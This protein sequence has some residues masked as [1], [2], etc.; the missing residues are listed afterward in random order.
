M[1]R[2]RLYVPS[3]SGFVS[4]KKYLIM[5]LILFFIPAIF[6]LA[7]A[8]QYY[9]IE[10]SKAF[11]MSVANENIVVNAG[12]ITIERI[13]ETLQQDIVY[14]SEYHEFKKFVNS[15]QTKPYSD[16]INDYKLLMQS[17]PG[18]DQIRWID[19]DGWE[20]I[21]LDFKSGTPDAVEPESFQYKGD[22]YYFKNIVNLPEGTIYIS[23]F[24][25]NFDK[26][27]IEKPYKP[28]IRLGVPVVDEHGDRRGAFIINYL[29]K[30]LIKIMM[31]NTA[32]TNGR[33]MLLNSNGYW[34]KGRNANEEFGF[35]LGRKD[36]SLAHQ[37]P[38]IWNRISSM[39]SGSF[40]DEK[41]LWT[42]ETVYPLKSVKKNKVENDK[43]RWKIVSFV[44]L[45]KVYEASDERLKMITLSTL[46]I[47]SI[48]LIGS[49]ILT[50]LYRRQLFQSH[51]I[52]AVQDSIM[53]HD[54][55][56]K[57]VY[58]NE[59]AWKSRGYSHDEL[60]NMTVA[61]LDAPE[62]SSG[63]AEELKK[64]LEI[65]R[66]EGSMTIESEHICK[67][68]KHMP[69]EVNAKLLELDDEL[70]ILSSVRDITE[71]KKAR[72]EIE[73]LSKAIEQVDDVVYIT[74]RN[75]N[76]TY[77]NRA[78][79]RHTGYSKEE[80]IGQPSKIFK[81]GMHDLSFYKNLWYTILSGEVFRDTLINRKKN[82]DLYYEKK[83]ISPLKDDQYKVIGFVSTGKDVTEEVMI[84]QEISKM[85]T[86]DALT[87]VYNRRKL[88]EL[89]AL[90]QERTKRFGNP[91]SLLLLDID[92]FK[93]VNDKYGHNVGD[94]VLKHFASVVKENIRQID[95]LARWGGEEF[96]IVCPGTV[97]N[98]GMTLANKI[99]AAVEQSSFP[100][101]ERV[102]V[103]IGV[104]E[105][106]AKDSFASMIKR[107]DEGLYEAKAAGRN[108]AIYREE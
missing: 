106:L 45:S 90:E 44:P 17:K 8:Y 53:V 32:G 57:F 19:E 101:V 67:N 73:K 103:S 89:F 27:I 21:R 30:D 104:S 81:S 99:R 10:K 93:S 5:W 50:V 22:R 9:Q 78:F 71:H 91:L 34:L 4:V 49:I 96:I 40:K 2:D 83:T 35:M 39:E 6:I 18:Y 38:E 88:E 76:I 42:F 37:N 54:L 98:D 80:I 87:G 105:F 65:F 14:L 31:E 64:S 47:L 108:R 7:I 24:D 29:G 79:C 11:Q 16:I 36:L 13:F 52:E 86:T 12:K 72:L 100:V 1:K 46:V 23:P 94:E 61:E 74:D 28:M 95:I 77:V 66:R 92:H 3:R 43:Y 55:D 68:G 56:G 102:T 84:Q 70:L 82:G 62:Y 51:I 60:M 33:V 20:K 69:V 41:G 15:H 63:H 85:A 97:G 26:G 58:L 48:V 25:L 75:G 59:N 107:A